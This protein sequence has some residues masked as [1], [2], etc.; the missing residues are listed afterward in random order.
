MMTRSC[1]QPTYMGNV[2][3]IQHSEDPDRHYLAENGY[4]LYE[5]FN[6]DLDDRSTNHK[7]RC[8]RCSAQMVRTMMSIY[9][10]IICKD[11]K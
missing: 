7:V 10:G 2:M 3:L 5:V 6:T 9:H 4:N 11:W 8:P 1:L